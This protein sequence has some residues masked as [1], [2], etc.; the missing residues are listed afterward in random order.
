[1]KKL[2]ATRPWNRIDHA[3]YSVSSVSNGRHNMNICTYVTPVSLKPKL[4][5]VAFYKNTL[6]EKLVK[7]QN[8]FVLQFLSIRHIKLIPL[9]GRK[10]GF[11]IDKLKYIQPQ[12]SYR[13]FILLP[14]LLAFVHLKV[15]QWTNGGDHDC[16]VC[17]VVQFK[18]IRTGKAL[19][20]GVL[21]KKKVIRA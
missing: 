7:E 2:P 5:L 4:Y 17:E 12:I 8:E 1:M 20:T 15:I 19:T 11:D 13:Q 6:T 18:N 14:D 10:S 9:L 16:A 3:V 21:R